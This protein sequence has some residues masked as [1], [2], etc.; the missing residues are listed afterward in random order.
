MKKATQALA[1]VG[2]LFIHKVV[3]F[4]GLPYRQAFLEAWGREWGQA[5]GHPEWPWSLSTVVTQHTE[6]T[7][8]SHQQE[9][10]L[11]MG[12][13]SLRQVSLISV[14]VIHQSVDRDRGSLRHTCSSLLVVCS[15]GHS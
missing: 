7:V 2:A 13:I 6:T 11:T 4:S 14:Q 12:E 3:C 8:Q 10:T 15:R 9:S 1:D 5:E